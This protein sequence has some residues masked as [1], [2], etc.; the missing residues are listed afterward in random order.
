MDGT[1][2]KDDIRRAFVAGAAWWEY[3]QSMGTMWGS[4]RALAE[5]EAERRY[6]AA[7]HPS[8]PL[9][10]ADDGWTSVG[11]EATK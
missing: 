3:H 2:P 1:W 11:G 4:D 5:D 6:G 9:T 10:G 7:I 8:P